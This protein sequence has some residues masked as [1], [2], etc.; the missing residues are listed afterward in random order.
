MEVVVKEV[1]EVNP[2][3]H[4]R[5]QTGAL[6]GASTPTIT[7]LENFPILSGS[8][9]QAK[10]VELEQPKKYNPANKK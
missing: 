4:R 9:F 7:V 8:V 1:K 5:L 3:F 2:L 10:A 6:P